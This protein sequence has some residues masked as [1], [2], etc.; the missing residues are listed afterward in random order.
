[1]REKQ[2]HNDAKNYSCEEPRE[3]FELSTPGLQDQCSNHWAN[4]ACSGS[5]ASFTNLIFV[6]NAFRYSSTLLPG[7]SVTPGALMTVGIV[8]FFYR[9]AVLKKAANKP[10]FF[11][12]LTLEFRLYTSGGRVP[13]QDLVFG[14][15]WAPGYYVHTFS[16]GSETIHCLLLPAS[17]SRNKMVV[18][19]GE[20]EQKS[21]YFL[22]PLFPCPPR[23]P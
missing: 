17:C 12:V 21:T 10:F 6:T 16:F 1:M 8:S 13:G 3:R 5:R 19:L 4:E 20:M 14:H 11:K 2:S 22:A 9:L 7:G 15:W 23:S 18:R